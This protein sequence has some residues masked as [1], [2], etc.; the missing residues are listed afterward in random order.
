M[1]ILKVF[2]PR[3]PEKV[4]CELFSM[5]TVVDEEAKVKDNFTEISGT[6]VSP[7]K[8]DDPVVY[9]LVRVY[10]CVKWLF[11]L[12]FNKPIG[13]STLYYILAVKSALQGWL[14]GKGI[15][16]VRVFCA[17]D[18]LICALSSW[19]LSEYACHVQ[20]NSWLMWCIGFVTLWV[21]W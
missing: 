17:L 13:G 21:D 5:E 3:L 11:Q 19:V 9:H 2:F 8:S 4:A 20:S 14:Y 10:H 1:F 12:I 16:V 18:V 15:P 6:T 7:P